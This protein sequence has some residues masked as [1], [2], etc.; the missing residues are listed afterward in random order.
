MDNWAQACW[1]VNRDIIAKALLNERYLVEAFHVM[2]YLRKKS[3]LAYDLTYFEFNHSKLYNY[4]CFEC[5][6]RAEELMSIN[7]LKL[8][9]IVNDRIHDIHECHT[10]KL[11]MWK[12]VSNGGIIVL[13]KI[14]C[15]EA[16]NQWHWRNKVKKRMMGAHISRPT[17]IFDDNECQSSIMPQSQN[18]F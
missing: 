13:C 7:A 5:N 9:R 15:Y 10:D 1:Y 2:A 16:E 18:L 8:R 12:S 4:D 3:R 14:Y 11:V 6:R 17:S